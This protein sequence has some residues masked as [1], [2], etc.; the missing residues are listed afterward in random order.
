M[1]TLG[2]LSC[3]PVR[4]VVVESHWK[5]T[6]AKTRARNPARAV[7]RLYLRF[8]PNSA[9]LKIFSLAPLNLEIQPP[10]QETHESAR[11]RT[12][13]HESAR[14]A[15]KPGRP[16]HVQIWGRGPGQG[17]E[18]ERSLAWT[19]LPEAPMATRNQPVLRPALPQPGLLHG[20]TKGAR[21][22]TKAHETSWPP[23][24][25]GPV[26]LAPKYSKPKKKQTPSEQPVF[27][28]FKAVSRQ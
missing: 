20:P 5:P 12:K 6:K 19:G 16:A 21:R 1:V 10:E 4:P 9:F 22:R 13:P 11:K 15:R 26:I 18:M 23:K 7:R 2:V 17:L 27:V 24:P 25:L 3:E 14:N 28:H 8:Y